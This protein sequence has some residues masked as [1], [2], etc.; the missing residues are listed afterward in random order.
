MTPVCE[1]EA[2]KPFSERAGLSSNRIKFSGKAVG[3]YRCGRLGGHKL[4]LFKP[5]H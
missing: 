3:A 5:G 4:G 1:K 2:P